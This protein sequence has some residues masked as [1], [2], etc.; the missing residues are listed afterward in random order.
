MTGSFE[1]T[2]RIDNSVM[3]EIAENHVEYME[4]PED[5]DC[6]VL[7]VRLSADPEFQ[8]I[9]IDEFRSLFDEIAEDHWSHDITD[10]IGEKMGQVGWL[11]EVEQE[12]N[13]AD[14]EADFQDKLM[15][16]SNWALEVASAAKMLQQLG[17][18]VERP[19]TKKR[20]QTK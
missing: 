8:Q 10:R 19:A 13:E 6:A 1:V 5:Y 16:E 11:A 18:T 12:I 14:A 17:W 4:L 15:R 2:V 7:Q 20:K 3:T 9:V